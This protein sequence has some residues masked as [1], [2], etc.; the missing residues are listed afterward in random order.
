MRFSTF[1]LSLATC[2]STI[3]TAHAW[4]PN[5]GVA[6]TTP[7]STSRSL[8]YRPPS[9]RWA[10][11]APAAPAASAPAMVAPAP[12][13]GLPPLQPIH[14]APA[15]ATAASPA[16]IAPPAP[17][18]TAA[19]T[20]SPAPA[21]APAPVYEAA[22]AAAAIAYA[23]QPSYG[24]PIASD[25]WGAQSRTHERMALGIEGFYDNYQEDSVDLDNEAINGSITAEYT[26]FFDSRLFAGL[27]GRASYGED[28]YS[29]I[30]GQLDGIP[31]WE[32]EARARVGQRS[33]LAQG[34]TLDLYSGLGFRYYDYKFKGESVNGSSGYDRRI[35]Q[36][37]LPVGVT[38]TSDLSGWSFRKNI[39][40]DALLWGNV[41]SRLGTIPGYGNVENRQKAFTGFG[42]RGELTFANLNAQGSGFEFGPFVRYW[43]VDDSENEFEPV[44]GLTFIEPENTRLQLGATLRYLF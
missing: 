5:E 38:H 33:M 43:Y 28:D 25:S 30:S 14:Y 41:S 34:S 10:N 40:A 18:Y 42:L 4:D 29:S 24:E 9:V 36:L 8:T 13:A 31:V 20:Y 7:A 32:Y 27:D 2:I 23:P 21:Y 19:P 44:S 26:H 1:L 16:V 35:A 15:P 11:P 17:A 22:P 3:T 12:N 39:E 37:Y 6:T